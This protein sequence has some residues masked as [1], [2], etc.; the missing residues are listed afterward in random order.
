[1][2][3]KLSEK[4]AATRA[5]FMNKSV[6]GALGG[7]RPPSAAQQQRPSTSSGR[8]GSGLGGGANMNSKP[9]ALTC[10]LCG[11]QHFSRRWVL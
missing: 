11:T 9:Q 6:D 7:L 2:K 4:L 5:T 1:M 8:G 10:Y 3:P